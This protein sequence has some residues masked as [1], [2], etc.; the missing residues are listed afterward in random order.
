MHPAAG[1]TL[2]AKAAMAENAEVS[3]YADRRLR[4][5]LR[6]NVL[7]YLF[8]ARIGTAVNGLGK[9]NDLVVA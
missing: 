9:S 5:R 8:A 4:P 3:R 2:H 1:Y 6:A 7:Q